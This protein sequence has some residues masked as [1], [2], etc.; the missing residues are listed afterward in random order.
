MYPFHPRCGETVV[1]PENCQGDLREIGRSRIPIVR[2]RRV[3]A[4][5]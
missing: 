2:I 3:K 1:L 4:F 5:P